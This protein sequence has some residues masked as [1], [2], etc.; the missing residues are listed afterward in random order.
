M[1]K[2]YTIIA[3][4]LVGLQI[5]I[6]TLNPPLT[7][8]SFAI[9]R[10]ITLQINKLSKSSVEVSTLAAN[11][12]PR[13]KGIIIQ[14]DGANID[15]KYFTKEQLIQLINSSKTKVNVCYDN[16][17]QETSETA[18]SNTVTTINHQV[19]PMNA[20]MALG[21]LLAF[22][23]STMWIPGVGE[24]ELTADG[25][26]LVGVGV[27]AVGSWLGHAIIRAFSA[28]HTKNARP[29]TK[30]KHTKPRPGRDTTKNRQKPNWKSRK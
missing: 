14:N 6:F 24:V 16:R 9:E 25:I 12:H 22:E 23:G 19:K 7:K 1:K 26:I 10:K 18:T 17:N 11:T 8:E 29:S 28:E 4:S 20:A 13:T 2:R 15:G 30:D 21:P 27:I 5:A 3:L